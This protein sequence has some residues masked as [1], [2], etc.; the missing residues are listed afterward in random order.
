MIFARDDALTPGRGTLQYGRRVTLDR[1]TTPATWSGTARVVCGKAVVEEASAGFAAGPDGTA[2]HPGLRHQVG[3]ISKL[4][5]SVVVLSLT[6]RG[7]L[8]L[9]QPI[10]RWLDATP[11]A[12]DKITLRQLLSQTSGLGHWGDVPGLP[13]TFLTVP[14]PRDDLMAM[15]T[16]APLVQAPA[17]AWRYS[18]PGFLVAALVVEAATGTDYG[19]IAAEL[20]FRRARLHATT[21]GQFPAGPAG[22]ALGHRHGEL[23][24]VPEGFTQIPGTGDVWST[25]DDLV[26]LSQALRTGAVL[27][28]DVA[29]Q[30][31]THHA[32]IGRSGTDEPVVNEGYGYG[33]FLGQ[34]KGRPARIHPGDNPGY[35]SL[36][37]YLPDTDLDLVVLCNEDRPS[38]NAALDR[39]TSI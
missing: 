21:S 29:A 26:A 25:V 35:Q 1:S 18:G 28:E 39:L 4:I 5:V 37:A 24:S 10:G 7:V 3:S 31:W 19:D 20:V 27:G 34:V 38:V 32:T 23:I 16:E 6:E 11:R 12:W 13:D 8:S 14:P 9:D 36:L 15:I 2:C 22:I 30:L 17:Q 33:T